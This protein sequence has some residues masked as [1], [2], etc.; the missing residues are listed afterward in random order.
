MKD[1]NNTRDVGPRVWSP[2]WIYLTSV[3]VVGL[4]LLFA[5]LYGL[6]LP[7]AEALFG[8]PLFWVVATMA[9]L[10]ELR[11]IVTP[12]TTD[13]NGA[14][15]STPFS[16]AL[17][18]YAGLPAAVLVQAA[19][20]VAAG[21]AT[22]KAPHRTA[23][24]V[25]QYT[26]SLG[27]A[28][29]VFGLFPGQ[30]PR[31]WV[32]A[33][34]ELLVV[35][36][37]ALVYFV[38]NLGLVECAVA[39]HERTSVTRILR[40]DFGYQ[41]FV[42]LALLSVAPLVVV[43][44]DTSAALVPLFG[45]PLIAVHTNASLSMKREYQA[46]HD[47]L[48]GL[49]NRKLLV[50][51][52]EEAL[53]EAERDG[54][55]AGLLLL[56]LD[57]FKEVNDTLG[58]PTGDRL[59]QTVAHRLAHSV[60]PGD[61]VARLGGDEFAILLPVIRDTA[62]AREVAARVRVALAEPV[63]L[64]GLAFELEASV[65][66][67]LHP[68]HAPDFELLMQRADVAMYLA[69]ESRGGVEVYAADKDRNSTMRLSLFGE[70]RRAVDRG[71]LQLH[72]QPKIALND[73]RVVG[74]EALVRWPHP[75]RGMLLPG[76]FIP[77]AE[78]SYLMRDLTHQVVDMALAQVSRWWRIGLAVQ[79]SV[80]VS[81]RDLLDTALIEVIKEGLGTHGVSPQ[82][83]QLEITERVLMTDPAYVGDTVQG[84]A[85]LGVALALDDFG[86]GYSSLARLKRLPVEEI[87]IDSSIVS[88]AV[89]SHD[90]KVITGSI[91]DLVRGLGL[92]TVAEGVETP[93]VA[94]LLTEMG[95]DAAQGWHFTPAM[96]ARSAT[97]WL[98]EYLQITPVM[99]ALREGDIA[100]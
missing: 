5:S 46:H 7:G 86:T 9:V 27:A 92:R 12:G 33:G 28:A 58:H 13:T 90:D 10:G 16:F 26:V 39:M 24:N 34:A 87:K 96:D 6:G 44:M 91:I 100:G 83:L 3:T 81:A 57:R 98:A 89:E 4:A 70:L 35:A 79:V 72:Y 94:A 11:P 47:E 85:E 17:L 49:P 74:M 65:G 99:P 56:D 37:A 55:R 29:L 36:L 40:Q 59:L 88:R 78:Q 66:I 54:H 60:R 51:R 71:E 25:S 50:V 2:L 38:V 75:R 73:G 20:A 48:T 77:M 76:D 67:A 1:P 97:G 31:P 80:N 82:A 64:D 43:A 32:P 95:C 18:I 42:S 84:L 22:G 62:A 61:V 14:P 8:L 93:E 45:L 69:K 41:L 19:A 53:A 52:T 68:D 15:T 21:L 23:F 63:R 30:P